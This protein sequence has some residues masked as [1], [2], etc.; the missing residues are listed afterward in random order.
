MIRDIPSEATPVRIIASRLRRHA[1]D[2]FEQPEMDVPPTVP[3]LPTI[4][5]VPKWLARLEPKLATLERSE[6]M[7]MI[8]HQSIKAEPARGAGETLKKQQCL[9]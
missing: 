1:Q 7:S 2:L 9:F 8:E 5:E 4:I 6:T 3:P